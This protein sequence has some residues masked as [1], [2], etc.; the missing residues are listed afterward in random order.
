[1]LL[2]IHLII[3]HITIAPHLQCDI[4][5]F[6][7]IKDLYDIL[8]PQSASPKGL[9]LPPPLPPPFRPQARLEARERPSRW[10]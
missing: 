5:I 9:P 7:V 8:N 2:Y 6:Q 4:S 3:C 1:M 10:A